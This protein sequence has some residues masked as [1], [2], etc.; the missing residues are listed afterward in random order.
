MGESAFSEDAT[1][2]LVTGK[3][4][5]GSNDGSLFIFSLLLKSDHLRRY[6]LTNLPANNPAR[7]N[8]IEPSILKV[9]ILNF[10]GMAF[11]SI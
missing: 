9:N 1:N 10:H 8:P 3:R 5:P 2:R 4:C 7:S 6:R 11:G